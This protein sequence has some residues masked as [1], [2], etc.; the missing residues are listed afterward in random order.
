MLQIALLGAGTMGGAHGRAYADV[1]GAQVRYIFDRDLDRARRLAE[2]VGNPSPDLKTTDS[3]DEI[4]QDPSVDAVDICMPTDLHRFF[5]EKAAASGKHVFCEKPIARSLSDAQAM[6]EACRKAN[7]TFM[8]GHV[9]R[10][11]AEYVAARNAILSGEIGE[12]KVIRATR[13]SGFPKWGSDNWYADFSRSGGP[14]LDLI[15]HDIDFIRWTFGEATRVYAKAHKNYALVT[16][17]LE[18]GAICHVEGS[19]AH[20]D[21]FP[22]TTKLEVAGT[23]GLYTT[24]NQEG[25]PLRLT[26]EKDGQPQSIPVNPFPADPYALELQHFVDCVT[27][28]SEPLVSGEEAVKSLAISLAGLESVEKETPVS[29]KGVIS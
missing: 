8:V 16:L 9:V 11:F 1:S 22:F 23:D 29:L 20:P 7:V 21:H 3:L 4:L 27:S 14:I 13:A 17:R 18:N 12:P 24:T 26:I 2:Q 5:T 15:I 28:G 6:V 25:I 10:F 19:W